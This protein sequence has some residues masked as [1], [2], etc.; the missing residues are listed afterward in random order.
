MKKLFL[1]ILLLFFTKTF[2]AQNM[3]SIRYKKNSVS[4]ELLGNSGILYSINY[5]RKLFG[6]ENNFMTIR[7]GVGTYDKNGGLFPLL[8]NGVFGEGNHHIEIGVGRTLSLGWW[9]KTFYYDKDDSPFT[10]NL[11]YRYQRPKG[12]FVFR[13]GWTPVLVPNLDFA[14]VEVL[15]LLDCGASVGYR[16]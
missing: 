1:T 7:A 2:F 16:F 10:A 11:M 3:D 14:D 5:E 13:I 4:F 8:I 9:K 15:L 6:N 12:K